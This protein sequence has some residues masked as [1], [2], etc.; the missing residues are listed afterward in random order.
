[1]S[2]AKKKKSNSIKGLLKTLF[3]AGS[4]AIFFRSIFFE[5]F[6]IPS[7]SMIPTL[8]VGDYLFVSKY[9]YENSKHRLPLGMVPIAD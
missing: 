5:P 3:I 1:M 6:N 7:G 4:I 8:L 9:S 2:V